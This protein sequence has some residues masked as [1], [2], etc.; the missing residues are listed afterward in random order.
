MTFDLGT[1]LLIVG[2]VVAF[3]VMYL[4]FLSETL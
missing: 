1:I 4:A 3:G 2:F